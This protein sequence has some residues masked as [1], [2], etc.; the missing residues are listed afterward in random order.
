MII[1]FD[2]LEDRLHYMTMESY[3]KLLQQPL[4]LYKL[5]KCLLGIVTAKLA[6]L[7]MR[8]PMLNDDDDGAIEQ[9]IIQAV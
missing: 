8:I 3:L 2:T 1:R 5:R 6:I 4:R 9:M 7:G